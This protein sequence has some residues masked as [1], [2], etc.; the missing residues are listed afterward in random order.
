MKKELVMID[1]KEYYAVLPKYTQR[2][3]CT[4]CALLGTSCN[5][6]CLSSPATIF[7]NLQFPI[8]FIP[9]EP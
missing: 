1:G 7:G 4:C 3:S 6:C 5:M 2:I 8:I 9:T